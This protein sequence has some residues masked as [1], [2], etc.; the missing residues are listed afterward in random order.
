M[1]LA[2]LTLALT[3]ALA[4]YVGS[5]IITGSIL[6][7]AV[8]FYF[9]VILFLLSEASCT[10]FFSAAAPGRIYVLRLV[11]LVHCEGLSF[12]PA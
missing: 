3:L 10:W 11:R 2:L 9:C 5:K 12:C 8:L 6:H 1:V 7:L 4:L